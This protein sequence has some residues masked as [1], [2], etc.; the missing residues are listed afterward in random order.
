MVVGS[1]KLKARTE[2]HKA[3]LADD[4]Q[5]LKAI[6]EAKKREELLNDWITK[7][8]KSTYVRISDG[9]RNCDIKYPGWIKELRLFLIQTFMLQSDFWQYAL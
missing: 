7:K 9:W 1:G 4:F 5:A 6:V 8:Q 2:G 3:N